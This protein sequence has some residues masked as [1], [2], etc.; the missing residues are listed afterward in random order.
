MKNTKKLFFLAVSAVA[1]LAAFGLTDVYWTNSSGGDWNSAA[2]WSSGTVPNSADCHVHV[3]NETAVTIS[4]SSADYTI[5][6][7]SF[8]GA[9]HAIG[10]SKC[11]VFGAASGSDAA[12]EIDVADG[13]AASVAYVK[14]STDKGCGLVKTGNGVLVSTSKFCDPWNRFSYFDVQCGVYSNVFNGG[15]TFMVG[16]KVYVHSGSKVAFSQLNTI[17]NSVIFDLE[18]DAIFDNC[19]KRDALGGVTGSGVV[20]NLHANTSS[21]WAAGP[22]D[23][24]GR[25]YGYV[26]LQ[27]TAN[28]VV[29]DGGYLRI[30]ASNTLANAKI[31]INPGESYTNILRFAPG[32]GSFSLYQLEFTKPIPV[33]LEDTNGEPITLT[34]G[35]AASYKNAMFAGCG[36]FVKS[37]GNTWTITNDLYAATGMLG[38]RAGTIEAGTGAEGFDAALDNI[39]RLDVGSGATFRMKNY[40]DTT[41]DIP[42]TGA[43]TVS[44]AG[45]GVW[46]MN[47]FSLTNGTL[48]FAAPATELVLAG[49]AATNVSSSFG[50]TTFKTTITGGDYAF[51]GIFSV[52]VRYSFSFSTGTSPFFGVA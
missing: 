45:R 30:G 41:W 15:D 11:L 46:T 17:E 32:V 52:S 18:E 16:G 12:P 49:G 51:A 44:P 50:P 6:G 5:G 22:L 1:S 20:T 23:F 39:S 33:V 35:F 48:A 42:I 38:V 19:G 10:G 47:N 3:T 28:K 13:I 21:I 37:N 43:G 36:N 25:L 4:L 7:L 27:P 14:A 31:D 9:N 8:S 34:A 40:A 2:N 29:G 26:S 24:D